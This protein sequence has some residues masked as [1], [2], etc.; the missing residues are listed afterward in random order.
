MVG[1]A[2]RTR[3]DV[4]NRVHSEASV[5]LDLTPHSALIGFVVGLLAAIAT[6]ICSVDAVR[7]SFPSQSWH[8]QAAVDA[9]AAAAG[10]FMGVAA[11]GPRRRAS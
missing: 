9:M 5:E 8:L 3:S 11:S 7:S 1:M 10:I 6:H 4:S 2:I